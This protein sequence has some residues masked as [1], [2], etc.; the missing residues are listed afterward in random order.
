M[1][2]GYR[3]NESRLCLAAEALESLP[4]GLYGAVHFV[5]FG[6]QNKVVFY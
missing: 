1:L 5:D 3:W 2:E 4:P 6:Y